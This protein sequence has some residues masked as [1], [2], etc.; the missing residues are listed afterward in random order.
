MCVEAKNP[1]EVLFRLMPTLLMAFLHNPVL[2]CY[3]L[4][5]V[6]GVC[7]CVVSNIYE[8][9]SPGICVALG[10]LLIRHY[11]PKSPFVVQ[12][13]KAGKRRAL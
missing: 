11:C 9:D 7:A 6:D 12:Q 2:L 8:R 1:F 4:S 5:D 10:L 13:L 3:R